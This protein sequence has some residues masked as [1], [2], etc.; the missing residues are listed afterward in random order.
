MRIVALT[1][2]VAAGKSSV[3]AL[4]RAWGTPVIDADALVRELQRPG[5]PVLARIVARFGERILRA[6]GTLDRAAMRQRML[7]DEIARRDLE[8]IV[9]PALDER[10]RELLAH[11]RARGERLVVAEIPLLFEAADPAAYD[12]I[13]VVDAP[14]EERLR[15]LMAERGLGAAEAERLIALQWPAEKKRERATWIIENDADRATLEARARHV[16]EQL[17]A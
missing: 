14:V 3:A 13:V 7:T 16:W 15:R 17:T 1:G 9:H 5:E 10:R 11:A 2:T 8:L 4:F 12:A 6:D